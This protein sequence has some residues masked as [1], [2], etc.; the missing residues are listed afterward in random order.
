MAKNSRKLAEEHIL[1]TIT[2]MDPSGFNT[3][4]YKKFFSSMSDT[5]FDDYMKKLRDKKVKLTIYAP[6]LKVFLKNADLLK[7]ANSL[8]LKLFER[9]KLKDEITGTEYITPHKYLVLKLPVRR[10]R[11]FLMHKLSVA[12]SDKK[13]DVLTGQV[14]KPDQAS[15]IS[16]VEA[17]LL[18]SRGL[19]STLLEF[20]KVRGGDI[21]AFASMK[22]QLEDNGE[23]HLASIDQA[24]VPRSAIVMKIVLQCMYLDNN[25]VEGV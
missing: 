13:I 7:A 17:E 22:Q 20:M 1:K 24:S 2:L 11:Q 6:N 16:F 12:E 25:F 21:H 15:S 23:V 4:K 5:Q 3:E 8:N 19:D 18:H 10:A 14:T 9:L